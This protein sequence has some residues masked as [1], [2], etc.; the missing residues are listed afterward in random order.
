MRSAV[1]LRPG[2]RPLPVV[3]R[4]DRRLPVLDRVV[5]V[6]VADV[7]LLAA[8][9][10]RRPRTSSGSRGCRPSRPRPWP[11]SPASSR[12]SCTCR[13]RSGAWRSWTSIQESDHPVTPSFGSTSLT[14]IPAFLRSFVI[15]GQPAPMVASPD[16]N[17]SS[18]S[19]ASTQYLRTSGFWSLQL[20]LD[21]VERRLVDRVRVLGAE[22][23]QRRVGDLDRVV[24]DR[25]LALV[26][27][28][29]DAPPTTSAAA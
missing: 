4:L 1:H 2:V 10:A 20:V 9:R 22:E 7:E 12:S 3:G 11:G 14:F 26:L 18:K 5:V 19:V 23:L 25:D 13:R 15:S 6:L 28:V 8:L 24:R 16:L 17:R 27:R 21:L 29:V